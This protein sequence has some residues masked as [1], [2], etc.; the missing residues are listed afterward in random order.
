[1][2][3][4]I[5]ESASQ[6]AE[7]Q[8]E[9]NKR[10]ARLLEESS[11]KQI[12]LLTA[13]SAKLTAVVAGLRAE[14]KGDTEQ[15]TKSLTGKIESAQS[16]IR[17]ELE[18]R[19]NLERQSV[20]GKIET[21]R[22]EN[23]VAIMRVSST[24]EDK[25]GSVG[26]KCDADI[27]RAITQIREYVNETVGT[28][29]RNI[30][31]VEKNTE[32]ITKVNATL[33]RLKNKLTIASANATL[34]ADE[35]NASVRVNLADQQ[36][37]P[38]VD[39]EVRPLPSTSN[40]SISSNNTCTDNNS[41]NSQNG[42]LVPETNVNAVSEGQSRNADMQELTLP[43][44]T[45]SSKQVPLHF[46][47]DLDLYFKLRQTPEQLKLPLTLRAV[48]EPMAK[49]W[50]SST[51]D[52]LQNYNEFRKGFTDLLWNPN[53]QAGIRSQ[54]YLDKHL[55]SSG[56]S[57]VDHYIRYANMASSLDPPMTDMDL[58]SALTSHYESSIRQA[59]LCGNFKSTQEVLGFLARAQSVIENKNDSKSPRLD[60]VN[61]EQNRRPQQ[62]Y[63]REDRPP[64][65][66][67]NVNVQHVRRQADRR[68]TRYDYRRQDITG[69]AELHG[70]R[71]GRVGG[72]NQRGLNPEAR[73]YNPR[74]GGA[75]VE[76][77]RQEREPS[78]ESSSLNN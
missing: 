46:I 9:T 21:I 8:D 34:S 78:R 65:R 77:N 1:V 44:F 64:D 20:S 76:G 49:Q 60:Y 41:I 35:G 69:E 5:K 15:L 61:R 22:R 31:Q 19:L 23:E 56:E 75:P 70:R 42:N 73:H 37:H 17:E 30:R 25:L 13:E 16:K 54:I 39:V 14:I 43:M 11:R 48:Q 4:A 6:T 12:A 55:L 63:G 66:R 62:A 51:Y 2:K 24:M 53:R 27:M 45:D 29:S 52:K 36:V 32:E 26:E 28:M 74:V 18:E 50:I 10:T 33:A 67:P 7:L 68:G 38:V 3:Q 72:S 58:L 59:L 47:R 40:V 57:Y 71:Q